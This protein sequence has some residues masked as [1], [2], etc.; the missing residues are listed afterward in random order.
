[1]FNFVRFD[2]PEK[3]N[4]LVVL[5]LGVPDTIVLSLLQ[6]SSRRLKLWA[7]KLLTQSD[8]NDMFQLSSHT[9]ETES[10]YYVDSLLTK[11]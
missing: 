9:N 11:V 10:A 4:M 6:M 2:T 1:M 3:E 5:T 8:T 7:I